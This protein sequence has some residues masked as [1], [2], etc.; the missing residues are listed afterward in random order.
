MRMKR[1][2]Q[3]GTIKGLKLDFNG[4]CRSEN[5]GCFATGFWP[6]KLNQLSSKTP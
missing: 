2:F 6:L 3:C 4:R 1:A 5:V